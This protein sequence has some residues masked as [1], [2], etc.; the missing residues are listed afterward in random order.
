MPAWRSATLSK[1]NSNTGVFLWNLPNFKNTYFEEHL[2]MTAPGTSRGVTVLL[3]D[4]VFWW[5]FMDFWNFLLGQYIPVWHYIMSNASSLYRLSWQSQK[6]FSTLI[7]I[8]WT[9]VHFYNLA[10]L[11]YSYK[12]SQ[13]PADKYILK[14]LK[15]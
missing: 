2:Q 12:K 15:I 6:Q 1:R 9:K 11:A 3:K 13:L 5:M 10:S 14:T 7:K 4:F 8:N